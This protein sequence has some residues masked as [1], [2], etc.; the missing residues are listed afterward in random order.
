MLLAKQGVDVNQAEGSGST[1]LFIASQEGHS[2]V[3][4]MLLAKQ[5]V[6][7]NQADNYDWTPL[8]IASEKGGSSRHTSPSSAPHSPSSPNYDNSPSSPATLSAAAMNLPPA[9]RVRQACIENGGW[10]YAPKIG[11]LV[12]RTERD[13]LN[14]RDWAALNNSEGRGGCACCAKYRAGTVRCSS[15]H[16]H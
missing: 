2:E 3:V 14:L 11:N 13:G 7:V 6:D 4:S 15:T 9:A 8:Y 5:G 12:S 1:P 10:Q 16:Q